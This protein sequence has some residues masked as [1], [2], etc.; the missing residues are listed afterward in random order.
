MLRVLCS[1]FGLCLALVNSTK[2]TR[3]EPRL[4]LSTARHKWWG[5]CR[6]RRG[7]DSVVDLDAKLGLGEAA[8]QHSLAVMLR[9]RRAAFASLELERPLADQSKKS[10]RCSEALLRMASGLSTEIEVTRWKTGH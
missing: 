1:G 10:A 7:S 3:P 6:P 8:A 4:F 2:V 9:L 5:N